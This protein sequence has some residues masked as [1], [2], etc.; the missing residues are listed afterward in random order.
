MCVCERERERERKFTSMA[1]PSY[2]IERKTLI[3]KFELETKPV[4]D[5]YIWLYHLVN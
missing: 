1:H 3:A 2:A 5:P 4:I